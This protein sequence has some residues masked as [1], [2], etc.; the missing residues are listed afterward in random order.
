MTSAELISYCRLQVDEQTDGYWTDPDWLRYLTIG[1]Q[2]LMAY[3]KAGVYRQ[4]IEMDSAQV[5]DG[6][7]IHVHSATMIPDLTSTGHS[8][9]G[10]YFVVDDL[11][12]V[13]WKIQFTTAG[14]QATEENQIMVGIAANDTAS[15]VALAV[16]NAVNASALFPALASVASEV[17]TLT[18]KTLGYTAGAANVNVENGTDTFSVAV[19][20]QGYDDSYA[21]GMKFQKERGCVYDPEDGGGTKYLMR[22]IS[23]EEWIA[24]SLQDR[25]NAYCY[26]VDSSRALLFSPFDTGRIY[27]EFLPQVTE[28]GLETA[29]ADVIPEDFHQAIAYYALYQATL[30]DK[31]ATQSQHFL[32]AYRALAEE[33]KTEHARRMTENMDYGWNT[34]RWIPSRDNPMPVR[35]F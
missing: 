18:W 27:L 14:A 21:L 34:D 28:S 2:R 15:A 3:A 24:F 8:L 7:V 30:R 29:L 13:S 20:T 5:I 12:G 23:W 6:G 25:Q 1:A 32:A 11:D 31:E 35:P 9:N 17:L 26:Y 4:T 19:V 33:A 16:K 22:R 10:L